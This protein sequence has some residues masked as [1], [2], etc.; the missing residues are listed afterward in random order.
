MEEEALDCTLWKAHF[1]SGYGPVISQTNK[2]MNSCNMLV[3]K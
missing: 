2:K 1:G 3:N